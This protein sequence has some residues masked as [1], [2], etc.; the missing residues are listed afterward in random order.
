[1]VSL[2]LLPPP[3]R[4]RIRRS[5]GLGAGGELSLFILARDG[6]KVPANVVR[7]KPQTA[8]RPLSSRPVAVI[9]PTAHSKR[10]A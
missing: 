4:G 6:A 10:R 3:K 9:S 7:L 1:M 5:C 2:R 8:P